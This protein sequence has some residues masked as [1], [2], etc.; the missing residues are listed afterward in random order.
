MG[1]EPDK[2]IPESLG[3]VISQGRLPHFQH[4]VRIFLA[5]T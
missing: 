1:G 3:E 4:V 2:V 5:R